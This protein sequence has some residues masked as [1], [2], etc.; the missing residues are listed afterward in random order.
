MVI[1]LIKFKAGDQVLELETSP[2]VFQPNSTSR[3]LVESMGDPAGKR[4][5]DLGSGVGPI[6]IC[7]ALKGA[8][9]VYAVDIMPEACEIARRNVVRNG[10]ADTVTVI[11][12]DLF[13]ALNDTKFDILVDDVSGIADEAARISTWYPE[14]IPTGGLDGT[15][16]TIDMLRRS[17]VHLE[18]GGL[19]IFPVLSLAA[20]EKIVAVARELFGENLELLSSRR[21]PFNKP[22]QD[23]IERLNQLRDEGLIEFTQN[24]S[25][26]LW[27]LDIYRAWV[28]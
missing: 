10:V 4:V 25:R 22:L 20:S 27:T 8:A 18:N 6:S 21:I 1:E 7:A 16:Q 28:R 23:N 15:R 14:P 3:F 26:Y 2:T 12:G 11:Q 19:L 24:R 9:S 5:L 13:E 17:R